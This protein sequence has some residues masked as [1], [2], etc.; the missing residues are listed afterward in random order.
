MPNGAKS[1]CFTYNNP[2]ENVRIKEILQETCCTYAIWQLER[3]ASGT[4]HIQGYAE[5]S[6]RRSAAQV[7]NIWAG[8]WFIRRGSR[9]QARDYCRKEETR[10]AGPFELGVWDDV[11]QGKRNDLLE[12]KEMLDSGASNKEI[13]NEHFGSFI[14]YSRAFEVYRNVSR[15][16]RDAKSFATVCWGTT[17][18]GK[19]Q[20]IRD[21]CSADAFWVTA[22]SGGQ[23]HVW[24]DGYSGGDIVLDD[25]RGGWFSFSFLLRLLD[26]FPM[27]VETKG[28]TV[29]ICPR[30]IWLSSN[31]SPRDWYDCTKFDVDPLLRR[32][33]RVLE[34]RGTTG[35]GGFEGQ[36]E[37]EYRLKPGVLVTEQDPAMRGWIDPVNYQ[38]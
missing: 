2:P 28:G 4:L 33:D 32:L 8:A 22:P 29:E 3:A 12:V 37:L 11:T 5:F 13:A 6:K 10:V 24:W 19:S 14:R 35:N 15:R 20:Y 17:G 9:V 27:R 30:Q 25:F 16:L 23:S 36:P 18:L 34:F 26:R 21:H 38:E 1:W 31:K 7:Q